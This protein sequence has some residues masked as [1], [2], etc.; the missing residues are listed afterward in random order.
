LLTSA[1][2]ISVLFDLVINGVRFEFP[3]AVFFVRAFDAVLVVVEPG[4]RVG[5]AGP[6]VDFCHVAVAKFA[7]PGHLRAIVVVPDRGVASNAHII[8]L[9]KVDHLAG[10]FEVKVAAAAFG[11]YTLHFPFVCQ[12]D[13]RGGGFLIAPTKA[14][15]SNGR[16][17]SVAPRYNLSPPAVTL[18]HYHNGS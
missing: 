8:G 14:G 3:G 9:S 13:L 7:E 1:S 5:F 10:W 2:V 11:M 4:S 16:D 17:I 6:L 12:S 18:N 15:S